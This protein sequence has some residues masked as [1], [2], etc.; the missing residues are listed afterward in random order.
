MHPLYQMNTHQELSIG[1][2][3]ELSDD[4]FFFTTLQ[5]YDGAAFKAF[6]HRYS[7]AVYGNIIRHVDNE[8][9]AKLILEQTFCEAWQ[10]FPQFDKTKLR[11]FTWINQLAFQTIK[12]S[13]L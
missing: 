4:N 3:A 2:K 5:A 12:K 1:C 8:E 7:A 10:S 6:Y 9:K 11:I 13:T